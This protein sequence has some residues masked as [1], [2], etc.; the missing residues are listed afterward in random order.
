[1]FFS[2][3]VSVGAIFYLTSGGPQ[4]SAA[5]F[6]PAHSPIE[7]IEEMDQEHPQ[8][9]ARETQPPL[10]PQKEN[11]PEKRQ[12]QIHGKWYDYRPDNRYMI[13]GVVTYHVP[14]KIEHREQSPVQVVQA[15]AQPSAVPVA[16]AAK[17][18]AKSRESRAK[19]ERLL[20]MANDSPLSVYTP[21]GFQVLKEGLDAARS[22]SH[23][24]A[25]A[26][27]ALSNEE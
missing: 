16:A 26:L 2:L 11:A 8:E 7:D 17:A 21:S 23:E 25:K 14:K 15:K 27:E 5:V 4:P 20:K 13:D 19:S 1:M 6:Q 18:T 3:M 10:P 9:V 22:A 12:V 24:R